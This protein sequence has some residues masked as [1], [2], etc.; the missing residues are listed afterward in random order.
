M[1]TNALPHCDDMVVL[2][3]GLSAFKAEHF[4]AVPSHILDDEMVTR[5]G[6]FATKVFEGPYRDAKQWYGEMEDLVHQK[7]E[8][9]GKIYVFYT[10][11]PKRAKHYGENYV[12]GVVEV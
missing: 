11:C 8:L 10:T 1:Q 12:V 6:D 3:R 9:P 5:S 4:F 2:S 7:G